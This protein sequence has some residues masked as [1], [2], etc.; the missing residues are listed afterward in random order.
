VRAMDEMGLDRSYLFPTQGLYMWHYEG[1]EPRLGQAIARAYNNWLNDFCAYDRKRLRPVA[2]L[3]LHGPEEALAEV[4]RV[5]KLGFRAVFARPNPLNGRLLSDPAYE[6]IWAQCEEAGLAVCVHE[7]AH[8]PMTAVGIDRFQTDF[9]I[10]SCS[11][12]MEQMMA[13]LALLEGG[14]LERHPNLHVAFLE[15]GCGWLPF[16]LW[17]LDERWENVWFEVAE[18]VKMKPSAYFQRQCWVA[19]E[20]GPYLGGLV[21][22]IREG[23]N[24]LATA[25]PH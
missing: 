2:G 19:A 13:L 11:H 18:T 20:P 1:M 23:K 24:P 25:D 22:W 21:K 5:A 17:R 6:P 10:Q 14:V 12:P 7:G 4:R 8:A 3:S 16:W 15:S 9:A